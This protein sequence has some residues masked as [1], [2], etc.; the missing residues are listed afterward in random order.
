MVAGKYIAQHKVSSEHAGKNP[1]HDT[2]FLLTKKTIKMTPKEKAKELVDKYFSEMQFS[3]FVDDV[4]ASKQCA[5]IS[6]DEILDALNNK[7]I[8]YGSEYRYSVN[9]FYDKVKKEIEKI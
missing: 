7:D 4:D 2:S 5:L 1:A 9:E 8:I 6:V 3:E